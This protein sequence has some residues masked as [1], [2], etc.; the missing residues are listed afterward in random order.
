[1]Q[2]VAALGMVGVPACICLSAVELVVKTLQALKGISDE[3]K[4]S[5]LTITPMAEGVMDWVRERLVH[6]LWH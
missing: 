1:M 5:K 6:P 3:A 4:V 2:V